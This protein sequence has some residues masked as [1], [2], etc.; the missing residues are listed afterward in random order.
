[1]SLE[2]IIRQAKPTYIHAEKNE[3]TSVILNK[4]EQPELELA[5]VTTSRKFSWLK[6]VTS[7]VALVGVVLVGFGSIAAWASGTNMLN[8]A[9]KF[10]NNIRGGDAF[11]TSWGLQHTRMDLSHVQDSIR[12]NR[13]TDT[14]STFIGTNQFPRLDVSDVI[15]NNISAFMVDRSKQ[16][17]YIFADGYLQNSK[18]EV[19]RL[20][21]YH[22]TGG[23]V[24]ISGQT[25]TNKQETMSL[26][27]IEATYIEFTND[28]STNNFIT[29]KSGDWIFVLFSSNV[30]KQQL[31]KYAL[32]IEN[33]MK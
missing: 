2:T 17:F 12:E 28:K 6:K 30:P 15:V 27:G 18:D 14:L 21:L 11:G 22:N 19:V 23:D 7:I 1:M 33:Q 24:S 26:S 16:A 31:V 9:V 5:K 25:L 32:D 29:W 10:V 8:V 13:Y 20:N 3:V 4:L